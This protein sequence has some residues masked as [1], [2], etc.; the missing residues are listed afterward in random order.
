MPVPHLLNDT[1][2]KA[3]GPHLHNGCKEQALH[4]ATRT[5]NE[6]HFHIY[7]LGQSA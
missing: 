6:C 3:H 7:V 2:G 4:S 1:R 5:I